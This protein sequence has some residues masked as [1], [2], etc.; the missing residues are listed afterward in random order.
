QGKRR[1]FDLPLAPHGTDFQRSVWNALLTVE[2]GT[3]AT[4]QEIAEKID[5]KN[6]ARAVGGAC[7]CNP[8]ALVVPCHRII[9]TNR[10]LTGFAAGLDKK[11][12]LLQLEQKHRLTKIPIEK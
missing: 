5:N 4:Y 7:H 11:Q 9:G 6:A 12:W 2:Y 1:H 10:K 8:I 3:T